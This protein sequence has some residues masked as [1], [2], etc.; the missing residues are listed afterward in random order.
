MKKHFLENILYKNCTSY[1]RAIFDD[2]KIYVNL[3]N[4]AR[5]ITFFSKNRYR[6]EDFKFG[7]SKKVNEEMLL[8]SGIKLNEGMFYLDFYSGLDIARGR[9]EVIGQF[10]IIQGGP[11]AAVEMRNEIDFEQIEKALKYKLRDKQKIFLKDELINK[12]GIAF[13]WDGGEGAT[14][15]YILSILLD[16]KKPMISQKDLVLLSDRPHNLKYSRRTFVENVHYIKE[17]LLKRYF[18]LRKIE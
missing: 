15:A 10:P 8:D 9:E 3:D 17:V 12:S 2:Y 1:L 7:L 5:L 11:F 4:Y 16:Y 18:F 13:Y 14:T 6:I